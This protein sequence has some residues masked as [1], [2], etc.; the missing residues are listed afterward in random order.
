M[1]YTN[2]QDIPE[3]LKAYYCIDVDFSSLER[4]LQRYLETHHLELNPD[5]QRGH[6]WTE[7]QQIAYVEYL[8]TDP[9]RDKSIQI[10]FNMPGWMSSKWNYNA[11]M[12]CVD[13]LQRLT[14]CLRFLRNEIPAYGT[15]YK[16]YSGVMQ[17]GLQFI[18]GS[19]SNKADV[20]Q[21]YLQINAKGTPH[22]DEEIQKV[23]KMLE[24]ER[25]KHNGNQKF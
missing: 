14:A 6:V 20:L 7:E 9:D 2:F 21:W 24:Q 3:R 25:K 4:V 19:F 18:V 10:I 8:L 5:F 1:K 13:G 22:T 16:D 17:G 15:Y 12:V 23:Q 11:N